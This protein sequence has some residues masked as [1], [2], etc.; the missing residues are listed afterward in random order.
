MAHAQLGAER[1]R[2]VGAVMAFSLKRWPEAVL[3]PES[4]PYIEATPVKLWP[5]RRSQPRR[6]RPAR[7]RGAFRGL[8]L[9]VMVP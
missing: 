7:S 3:L 1:Q 4:L 5:A 2:A 6:W 8:G 9:V